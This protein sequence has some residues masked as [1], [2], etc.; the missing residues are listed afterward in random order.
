[1]GAFVWAS[2][3]SVG[4]ESPA[5]L[6]L[7]GDAGGHLLPSLEGGGAAVALGLFGV[8]GLNGRAKSGFSH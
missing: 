8:T 7:G 5:N 4:V 3:A 2:A 1:M 6:E